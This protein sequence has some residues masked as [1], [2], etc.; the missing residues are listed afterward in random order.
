MSAQ[1][2]FFLFDIY[3]T[4]C[5][6][7]PVFH[8]LVVFFSHCCVFVFACLKMLF[9]ITC[10]QTLQ[11]PVSPHARTAFHSEDRFVLFWLTF[12]RI[13]WLKVALA[14]PS[15]VRHKLLDW[16]IPLTTQILLLL[17]RETHQSSSLVLDL[18]PFPSH[19]AHFQ[20]HFFFSLISLALYLSLCKQ[21][22]NHGHSLVRWFVIYSMQVQRLCTHGLSSL[23]W[24]QRRIW[25][26]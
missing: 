22:T 21:W 1:I 10:H 25:Y 14:D 8:I 16:Q 23:G 6:V 5:V 18:S 26:V 12:T 15:L 9:V 3:F 4:I 19:H 24:Q 13:W 17:L 20:H 11:I 2:N 7:C